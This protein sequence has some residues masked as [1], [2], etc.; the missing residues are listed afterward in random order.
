MTMNEVGPR[1]ALVLLTEELAVLDQ[2]RREEEAE[3]DRE[4]PRWVYERTT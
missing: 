4:H 2:L 1:A 3:R